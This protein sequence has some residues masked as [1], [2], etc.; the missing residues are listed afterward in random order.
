MVD[1]NALNTILSA[2]NGVWATFL[3]L[4]VMAWRGYTIIP[5]VIT[6]WVTR[7]QAIAAE[8]AADWDR[9]RDEVRRLADRVDSL[10]RK[11]DECETREDEWRRRAIDAE[12]ALARERAVQVGMGI[13]RDRAQAALAA[14]RAD[15]AKAPTTRERFG[16]GEGK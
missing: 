11:V 16:N 10:E 5:A 3:V 8:K 12:A 2:R 9:L 14:D 15:P 4:L 13:A 1:L 7:R 6:A